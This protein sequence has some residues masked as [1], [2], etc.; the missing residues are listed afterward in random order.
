MYRA[1][2]ELAKINSSM[3]LKFGLV[4]VSDDEIKFPN[5]KLINRFSYNGNDY[6][7]I[8]PRP[9]VIIDISSNLMN[10]GEGWNTNQ[11]VS[12]N[13]YYLFRL[14]QGLR[15]LIKE[16]IEIKNLFYYRDGIL[17]VNNDLSEKMAIH[18]PTTSSKII[19][20]QPTVVPDEENPELFYE[21]CIFFI[22][23]MDNFA[24]LTYTEIEYLLY[25]LNK[26]D[27]TSLSMHLIEI[28]HIYKNEN[29]ETIKKPP[30]KEVKIEEIQ[31]PSSVTI[32]R[33]QEIPKI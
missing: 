9:F 11:S 30:S 25:E 27:M 32:I 8:N 10:K 33:D 22:N 15:R 29:V 3:K 28:V 5:N 13:K 21:G 1:S 23:T 14:I 16:F 18:I 20:I 17:T 12:L 26:I 19:R 4:I 24:Y 31:S 6:I 7:R 2:I